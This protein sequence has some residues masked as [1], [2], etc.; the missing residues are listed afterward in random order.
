V[1]PYFPG[2][3]SSAFQGVSIFIG[4]L[5]S[6]D[7]IRFIA[8]AIGGLMMIYIRFFI[9]GDVVKIG[10]NIGTVVSKGILVT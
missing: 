8:N 5:L 7:S 4:V 10:D 3:D 6:L 2:A 1:F 9:I